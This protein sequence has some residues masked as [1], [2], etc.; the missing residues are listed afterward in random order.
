MIQKSEVSLS[1]SVNVQ[2]QWHIAVLQEQLHTVTSDVIVF[3]KWS[4]SVLCDD[5]MNM[6]PALTV[7]TEE[8]VKIFMIFSI[9]KWYKFDI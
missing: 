8:N 9:C 7:I 4:G 2:G 3:L 5:V 1:S 6:S